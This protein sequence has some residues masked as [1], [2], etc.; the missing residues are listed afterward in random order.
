MTKAT[1]VKVEEVTAENKNAGYSNLPN[2]YADGAIGIAVTPFMG[3]IA[4]CDKTGNDKHPK[5]TLTIPVD[6]MLN[7]AVSIL[8]V[9]TQDKIVDQFDKQHAFIKERISEIKFANQ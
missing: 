5:F 3:K 2:Y 4:F 8:E 7:M 9:L 6:E 1:R